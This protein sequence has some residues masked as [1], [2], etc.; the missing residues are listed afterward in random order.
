MDIKRDDDF[1]KLYAL[2]ASR[3]GDKPNY[4]VTATLTG[5]FFAGKESKD[6]KGNVVAYSGYGHLGCCALL[7]ITAVSE[8]ESNPPSDLHVHGV[9]IKPDGKP[10]EG[11]QVINDV[12]GGSPPERQTTLK[13]ELGEFTFSNSGQQLRIESPIYRPLAITVNPGG[14]SVRVQ[15]QHAKSSDWIIPPCGSLGSGR[16]IGFSVLFTIPKPMKSSRFGNSDMQ[17]KS[18]FVY[19]RGGSAFLA[20]LVVAHSVE[21]NR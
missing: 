15:L 6:A 2:I 10:V 9:V 4:R 13:N 18:F 8:V 12:L 16:R 20:E 21:E 14:S 3:Q 1:R 5:M 7:V 17:T 11:F 19:P